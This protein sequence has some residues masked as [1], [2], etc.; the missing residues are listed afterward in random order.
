MCLMLA[1]LSVVGL[2]P[3]TSTGVV[4]KATNFIFLQITRGDMKISRV[5][6][7]KASLTL[8]T[9]PCAALGPPVNQSH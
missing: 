8:T 4:T 6:L 1:C 3:E 2:T 7:K 5:I 9:C